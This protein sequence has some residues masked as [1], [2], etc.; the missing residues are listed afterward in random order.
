M[1]MSHVV[2]DFCWPTTKKTG[3][4]AATAPSP[5]TLASSLFSAEIS[6]FLAAMLRLVP[7]PALDLTAPVAP[8][9]S[10]FALRNAPRA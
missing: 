5:L 3:D 10:A 9:A 7:R 6:A 1:R 4:S 2:P 8:A